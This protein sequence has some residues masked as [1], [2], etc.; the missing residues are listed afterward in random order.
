MAFDLGKY[1][2]SI[3]ELKKLPVILLLDVSGSMSGEKI[4]ALHTATLDMI[5][6][7]VQQELKETE[8]IVSII[9]FGRSISLHVG[10]EKKPYVPI[11]QV[12]KDGISE[13]TASGGTPIGVTLKLTKDLIEKKETTPPRSYRPIVVLVSDGQP[14]DD[15]REPMEAFINTGRTASCQRYSVAIGSDA[16]ENVLK[17]FAHDEDAFVLAADAGSLSDRFKKIST[18]AIDNERKS[19]IAPNKNDAAKEKSSKEA[20]KKESEKSQGGLSN[21]NPWGTDFDDL[22]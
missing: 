8:I 17:M 5:D 13:F 11:K 21:G 16:D 18:Q 3:P 22:D 1:K 7:F 15:W 9:T 2:D 4:K 10:D 19:R 12:Q 20:D 6:S 14:T